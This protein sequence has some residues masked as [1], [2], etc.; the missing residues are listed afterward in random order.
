[1]SL[2]VV[3]RPRVMTKTLYKRNS[4]GRRRARGDRYPACIYR[5]WR[6]FDCDHSSIRSLDDSGIRSRPQ[7]FVDFAVIGIYGA[8]MLRRSRGLRTENW[9]MVRGQFLCLPARGGG[10]SGEPFVE[11]ARMAVKRIRELVQTYTATW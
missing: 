4:M 1:M 7:V 11:N 10:N 6:I 3:A 8:C 2:R 5:G 9:I